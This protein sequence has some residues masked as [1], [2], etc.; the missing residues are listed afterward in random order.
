MEKFETLWG[1]IEVE[2]G[3]LCIVID[4]YELPYIRVDLTRQDTAKFAAFLNTTLGEQ[5]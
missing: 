3:S 5:S 4:D 1:R 2:N